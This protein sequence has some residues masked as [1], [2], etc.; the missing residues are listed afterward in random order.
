VNHRLQA[1]ALATLGTLACSGDPPPEPEPRFDFGCPEASSLACTGLYGP[2]GEHWYSKRPGP[3]VL[4]FEPAAALWSDGMHKQRWAYF[5]PGTSID[6]SDANAWRYPDG[7]KLWKEFSWQDRR[8]ETRYLEKRSGYWRMTTYRWTDDQ[9]NALELIDGERNVPGTPNDSY[10]VPPIANCARCHGGAADGVLGMGAILSGTGAQGLTTSELAR[11]GLLAPSRPLVSV[12]GSNTERDALAYLHVNCG[13]SCH[14]R[15]TRAE[16][17][18]TGLYL[19]LNVDEVA[20][21]A[22]TDTYRT[23][24]GKQSYIASPTDP[25]VALDLI[26]PG[27]PEQSAIVYRDRQRGSTLQ[28]PP[29]AT[30]LVDEQGVALVERWI[31]ELARTP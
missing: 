25:A 21:V 8:I 3:G 26:A 10:E 31:R 22:S 30:H 28:M 16:A 6:A 14:N 5:P 19:R 20:A 18:W 2:V 23:S 1:L 11:R 27:V 7:T 4:P 24:V 13:V 15:A 9:T 17:W 29:L 12:P